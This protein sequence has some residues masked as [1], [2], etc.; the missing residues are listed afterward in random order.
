[1]DVMIQ[2]LKS[3]FGSAANL[4]AFISALAVIVAA[5]STTVAIIGNRRSQK[6]YKQSILPQLSMKL[7]EYDYKLFLYIKNTGKTAA[8]NITIKPITI[9]NNGDR[10]LETGKLFETSFEL[11]PEEAVQD[12]VAYLGSN[13]MYSAF[14]QLSV[15][16]TYNTSVSKRE[17]SYL[18]T[19]T[20]LPAYTGKI[21]ADVKLDTSNIESS[22]KCIS[23]AT[24]RTANYLD[25][26][27]IAPFDE[28]NLLAG[29]SLENDLQNTFGKP[30]SPVVSH[31]ESINKPQREGESQNADA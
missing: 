3:L 18:R 30:N 24:L 12:T 17:T 11:Y 4:S 31:E 26:H 25:G 29:K 7:I 22:L 23:R 16:V 8:T 1:M 6:H 19:I 5:V 15:E 28:I 10:E 2:F 21:S 9:E 13:I 20:Y 14:P 27:Q